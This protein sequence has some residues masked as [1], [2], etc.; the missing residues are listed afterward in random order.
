MT[1]GTLYGIGVGPGDPE[2]LTLKAVRLVQSATVIAYPAAEQRRSIARGIVS[3]YLH[4]GQIELPLRFPLSS[5]TE[6][7][8]RFYDETAEQLAA[9]LS[10][11]KDVAV[12]CEGDPMLYG[13]FMYLYD[14]LAPRFRTEVVPGISS[15]TAGAS[16]L[17]LP[18]AY[19]ND[20]LS[21]IPAGLPPEAL[22][23]QLARSD[24]AIIIKVG[25]YFEKVRDAL[26][27][28]DLVARSYYVERVSMESQRTIPLEEVDPASAPYFSMILVPSAGL[29]TDRRD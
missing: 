27:D 9:H 19:R 2:L 15:L 6:P 24:A 12:L 17:G 1:C 23:E 8:R 20:V 13:T 7:A 25:R 11:G 4:E 26:R 29:R 28:L 22:R 3:A 14:R 16:A 18:L 5:S 21:V 10:A